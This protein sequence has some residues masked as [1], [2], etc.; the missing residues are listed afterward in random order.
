MGR[1]K[2]LHPN[3][4]NSANQA[5]AP[6][7]FKS[8]F[9]DPNREFRLGHVNDYE[10]V[11]PCPLHPNHM[12]AFKTFYSFEN[13]QRLSEEGRQYS[14][15]NGRRFTV[16]PQSCRG[17]EF[18][19]AFEGMVDND[20]IPDVGIFVRRIGEGYLLSPHSIFGKT[21]QDY[22]RICLENE[23]IRQ[24]NAYLLQENQELRKQL[25]NVQSFYDMKNMSFEKL[26]NLSF[27][28]R[29]CPSNIDS[30]SENEK[31]VYLKSVISALQPMF[32]M[33]ECCLRQLDSSRSGSVG[34]MFGYLCTLPHRKKSLFHLE[35]FLDGFSSSLKDTLKSRIS[36]CSTLRTSV[37]K[38]AS[39][40]IPDASQIARKTLEDGIFHSNL[41]KVHEMYSALGFSL[42]PSC[43]RISRVRA[44]IKRQVVAAVGMQDLAEGHGLP[45]ERRT[46]IHFTAYLKKGGINVLNVVRFLLL[47]AFDAVRLGSSAQSKT[48]HCDFTMSSAAVFSP[49]TDRK[50]IRE[51]EDHLNS[52]KAL[53]SF[54]LICANDTIQNVKRNLWDV[55]GPPIAALLRDIVLPN[56]KILKAGL[57]FHRDAN[58]ELSCIGGRE[59]TAAGEEPELIVPLGLYFKGDMKGFWNLVAMKGI[60][61]KC[62]CLFCNV[63]SRTR[64]MMF[65]IVDILSDQSVEQFC[66]DRKMPVDDFWTMNE[67]AMEGGANI[68]QQCMVEGQVLNQSD[69]SALQRSKIT[70]M[71]QR[72]QRVVVLKQ[73]NESIVREH[74]ILT[75]FGLTCLQIILCMLHMEM[76]ITT[77]F[78]TWCYKTAQ[79][80]KLLSAVQRVLLESGI[81]YCLEGAIDSL[82]NLDG[83]QC[84]K[85]LNIAL[86]KILDLLVDDTQVREQFKKTFE[87]WTSVLHTLRKTH[88]SELA[89]EEIET[90]DLRI[91]SFVINWV[92]LTG[93]KQMFSA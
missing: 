49:Q 35:S 78:V 89:N 12:G 85:M 14:G 86:P 26:W 39:C 70:G 37:E 82:P 79:K 10:N 52:L 20:G 7:F 28:G 17:L 76:R 38:I 47:I 2:P 54:L 4:D 60:R 3:R 24:A 36:S 69:K 58:N 63:C 56:G 84:A 88:I 18:L 32:E 92:A 61:D 43:T 19:A 11:A 48:S 22:F 23:Q 40:L 93:D 71:L 77:C 25:Q 91:N 29:E 45:F 13:M 87:N 46:E 81:N 55:F 15:T 66:S 1:S 65:H 62:C 33:F 5:S 80:L 57:H 74:D 41:R 51:Q 42:L 59:R 30:M 75:E 27:T 16:N 34:K 50:F 73:E 53:G 83:D 31:Q 21:I 72:G 6:R 67:G 44:Q 9:S 90:L 64:H 68:F 8:F